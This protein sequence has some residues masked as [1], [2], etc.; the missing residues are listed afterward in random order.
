VQIWVPSQDIKLLHF[1]CIWD[2]RIKCFDCQYRG[3]FILG[4]FSVLSSFL[5]LDSKY[6]FLIAIGFW[7][8]LTTMLSF[9]LEGV[10]MFENKQTISTFDNMFI[11]KCIFSL[12]AVYRGRILISQILK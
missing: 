11:I 6:S 9:A 3:S 4:V 10:T 5:N 8:T 12:I 7:G 2:C 1:C